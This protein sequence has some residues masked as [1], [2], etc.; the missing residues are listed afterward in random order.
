MSESSFQ[1]ITT[2]STLLRIIY[3]AFREKILHENE[4][5]F[6]AKFSGRCEIV[7][8]DEWDALA[9]IYT[10]DPFQW[11]MLSYTRSLTSAFYPIVGFE[12]FWRDVMLPA[13]SHLSDV[14]MHNVEASYCDI[15]S[16]I[17]NEVSTLHLKS[18]WYKAL[19][20][21][22]TSFWDWITGID[23]P[24]ER[25]F[26]LMRFASLRGN[27]VHPLSKLRKGWNKAE[28]Y[29]YA[30]EYG[31]TTALLVIAVAKGICKM[32]QMDP[33][34]N[35]GE[36]FR[37]HFPHQFSLWKATLENKGK[38]PLQ[39]VPIPVHP[40][41]LPYVKERFTDHIAR[42]NI[43]ICEGICIIVHPSMS[44]RT[45]MPSIHEAPYI[46]LPLNIQTTSVL[47]THSP[48]RVHSG[49]IL[50]RLLKD[51]LSKDPLISS[52][53]RITYEP[54]GIYIDDSAYQYQSQNPSY[55]LN[56]LYKQN[57][58]V[59]LSSEMISM[60]LSA[61]FEFSPFSDEPV[62]IDIMR[63]GGYDQPEKAVIYF[64]DYT[65]KILTAQLGLY[66]RYGVTLEGHQQNTRLVFDRQMQLLF[67][68]IGDLAGGIEIYLPLLVVNGYNILQDLHPVRKHV[69][70]TGTVPEQQILHT[71]FHYHLWP[72]AIIIANTFN[73]E[74]KIL[75]KIMIQ[76]IRD[77]LIYS[78]NH[79]A[80]LPF[81]KREWYLSELDRIEKVISLDKIQVKSVFKMNLQATHQAVYTVTENPFQHLMQ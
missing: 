38:N 52:L 44:I 69:F 57:P 21:T 12:P 75:S 35:V 58:I 77:T 53:M 31:N 65:Y 18:E 29:T 73:I 48:P 4:I 71:T 61:L 28:I 39:Y 34:I 10:Q 8:H 6:Q 20:L 49:P 72:L 32:I 74:L 54:L 68:V 25:E 13:L 50:S 22:H 41:Q 23:S 62:L 17:E 76:T 40:F 11:E 60:P 24:M 64:R 1:R 7:V 51:I 16:S 19:R 3:A 5:I 81:A 33:S 66:V 26:Q 67:T 56:V 37:N 47:R 15:I 43:V 45:L 46:K 2:Y 42:E 70:D 30:P 59:D 36:Y 14:S 55:H 78:Q 79:A 63:Y 27:P 80:K 9:V